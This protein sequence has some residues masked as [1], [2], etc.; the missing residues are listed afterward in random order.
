MFT[1]AL[2]YNLTYCKYT[3]K[4][5]KKTLS[6]AMSSVLC[7]LLI[8]NFNC[9]GYKKYFTTYIDKDDVFYQI[10]WFYLNLEEYFKEDLNT[11]LYHLCKHD[12]CT[13]T[14]CFIA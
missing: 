6:N 7:L 9:V 14:V 13:L 4:D 12:K 3:L 10:C 5:V 2:I 1:Y 11:L 8:I